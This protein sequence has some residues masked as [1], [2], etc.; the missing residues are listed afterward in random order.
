MEKKQI[1]MRF[2]FLDANSAISEAHYLIEVTASISVGQVKREIARCH[3]ELDCEAKY[4]ESL[5]FVP[6]GELTEEDRR[7]IED[8]VE[9][10][11]YLFCPPLPEALLRYVCKCNEGWSFSSPE[12]CF[13]LNQG[14]WA[15]SLPAISTK[16]PSAKKPRSRF[17]PGLPLVFDRLLR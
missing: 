15:S 14:I 5:E 4:V 16:Q 1:L 9:N 11:P 17:T 12:G 6:E 13:N 2:V 7:R 3:N 10:S 8:A